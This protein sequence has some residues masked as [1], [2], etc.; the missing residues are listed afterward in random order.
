MEAETLHLGFKYLY[1]CSQLHSL[2]CR[3]TVTGIEN[4]R[5]GKS[6]E[7]SHVLQTHQRGALLSCN[8][9]MNLICV[10]I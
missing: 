4:G 7:H 6:S 9:Y 3:H 2:L 5:C 8:I 10:I 1:G